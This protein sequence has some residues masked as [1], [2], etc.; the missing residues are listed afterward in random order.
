M[1][2]ARLQAS[3]L[4]RLPGKLLTHDQLLMLARD[5]VA[6]PGVPGLAQLGVVPT[7]V[8]LVVPIYLQ[9]YRLGGGKRRL[10]PGAEE[11]A[12]S[13]LFTAKNV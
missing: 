7:P 2:L 12:D 8:D 1:G 9:R 5:N 11:K 10:P 3:V 4:E 13:D 6:T